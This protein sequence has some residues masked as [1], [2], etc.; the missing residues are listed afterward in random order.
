MYQYLKISSS[1]AHRDRLNKLG[2]EFTYPQGN[3]FKQIDSI[4]IRLSDANKAEK[5]ASN[6]NKVL[7]RIDHKNDF[8]KND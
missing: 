3:P 7:Y 6:R 5:A 4:I 8:F 1:N 2:I